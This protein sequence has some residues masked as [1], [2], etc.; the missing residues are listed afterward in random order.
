MGGEP[1]TWFQI[2]PYPD[3]VC[4]ID[5]EKTTLITDEA[6]QQSIVEVWAEKGN[7][8]VIDYEHATTTAGVFH[9]PAAGRIVELVAGGKLGLLARCEWTEQAAEEIR[10]GQYFYDS[11]TF[12]FGLDDKRVYILAA[13]ALTNYPGSYNRPYITDHSETNYAVLLKKSAAKASSKAAANAPLRLVTAKGGVVKKT[14]KETIQKLTDSAE[15]LQQRFAASAQKLTANVMNSMRYAFDLPLTTTG[16]ELIALLTAI[17]AEIP[18][19]EEPI[20]IVEDAQKSAKTI[21]EAFGLT[22]QGAA[23][24]L[25]PLRVALGVTD[26]AAGIDALALAVLSLKANTVPLS[27]VQE[28]EQQLAT[29]TQRSVGER[30]DLLIS[31]NRARIRPEMEKEIRTLAGEDFA[32]AEKL[33]AMLPPIDLT[34]QSAGTAPKTPPATAETPATGVTVVDESQAAYTRTLAIATE[35]NISYAA[36]N[37]IRMKEEAA[38]AKV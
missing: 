27:K 19:G 8:L 12:Y 17:I 25:K 23:V 16:N 34:S 36:A 29:T 28:L 38:A 26:Q 22:T 31:N 9:A 1:P 11:P 2:F 6:S 24:D 33:V 3:Y 37:E 14:L 18:A 15:A 4:T 35:K 5:G 21:G 7:D 20:F 32:M 30:T 13:L 10:T